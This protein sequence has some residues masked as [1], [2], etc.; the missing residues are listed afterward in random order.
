MKNS[1]EILQ[2]TKTHWLAPVGSFRAEKGTRTLDVQLG[3]LTLYQLSYFRRRYKCNKEMPV[4]TRESENFY[5][6]AMFKR[7]FFLVLLSAL[8]LNAFA[9]DSPQ[10]KSLWDSFTSFFSSK[11]EPQGEGAM[12]QQLADIDNEIQETQ[13]RYSRERRS[14]RKSRYKM[15]LKELGARRDSLSAEI[16]KAKTAPAGSSSSSQNLSSLASSSSSRVVLSSSSALLE[17]SPQ[18]SS[19][20]NATPP[21]KKADPVPDSVVVTVTVTKFVH[22]TVFVRDTIFIRDTLVVHDTIYGNL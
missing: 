2:K 20:G 8:A 1:L 21:K 10:K 11:A 3:K 14:V 6:C 19:S 15:H 9:E 17:K 22:D 4:W 16:E 13:W 7:K 5:C 18:S 12:Y